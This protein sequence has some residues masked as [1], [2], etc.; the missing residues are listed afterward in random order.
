MKYFML[1][2]FLLII[3]TVSADVYCDG[4]NITEVILINDEPL[5][6]SEECQFGCDDINNMCNPTPFMQGIT[7]FILLGFVSVL[8]ILSMVYKR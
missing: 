8:V 3:G 2:P 6:L 1:I 7:F 4:D 5:T